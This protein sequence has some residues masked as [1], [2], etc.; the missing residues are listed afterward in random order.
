MKPRSLVHAALARPMTRALLLVMAALGCWYA[1]SPGTS[2]GLGGVLGGWRHASVHLLDAGL[3]PVALASALMGSTFRE[4]RVDEAVRMA[5]VARSTLVS[6]VV[7]AGAVL[8]LIVLAAF[9]AGCA[10]GGMVRAMA[11]GGSWWADAGAVGPPVRALVV[12]LRLA[13]AIALAGGLAALVGWLAGRDDIAAV[14]VVG[15]TAPYLEQGAA[16]VV[17]VPAVVGVLS[18]S[19]VGALR[20]VTLAN[21]GLAAPGFERPASVGLSALVLAVWILLG[22]MVALPRARSGTVATRSRSTPRR[23]SIATMGGAS[24]AVVSLVVIVLVASTMT[25][26]ALAS[27]AIARGLPW[28]WQ[29]SWRDAHRA[30]WA[31]DQ[32]VDRALDDLRAGGDVDAALVNRSQAISPEVADAVRRASRVERQPVSSMRAPDLVEVRLDFDEPITS[33]VTAFTV[34]G[35]RVAL[36]TGPDGH[37]RVDGVEGPV[38]VQGHVRGGGS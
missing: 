29:R 12:D 24:V 36:V 38:A 32:V 1:W 28:R 18:R 11:N 20:A 23:T 13:L 31:S 15:F 5:G 2:F 26:G 33:G 9:G 34:Y 35:L 10:I 25:F 30:G 19:P 14:I 21:G 17:R 4:R 16:L 6:S 8:G 37:W 7:T 22:V 3:V 27:P